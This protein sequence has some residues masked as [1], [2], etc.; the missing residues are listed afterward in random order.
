MKTMNFIVPALLAGF[1]SL[2][3]I[4]CSKSDDDV[5]PVANDT[6]YKVNIRSTQFDPNAIFMLPNAKITWVNADS[7]AH[8]VVSDDATSFN[9]GNINP[10]AGFSFT[11][12]TT[13]TY[14]Y[15]CGIHPAFK[16]TVY[17]VIR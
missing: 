14:T 1:M 13:G 9:S 10:G 11:P 4:S 7:I 6:A 17:V 2:S 16:G 5:A 12:V 8:S 3:M 15:H